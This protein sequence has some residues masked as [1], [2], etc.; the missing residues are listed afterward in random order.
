MTGVLNSMPKILLECY[1]TDDIQDGK[2]CNLE[3]TGSD[4]HFINC[5]QG[6]EKDG[7]KSCK[8]KA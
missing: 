3:P 4:L 2:R 8:T 1:L 5:A 7:S 6:K